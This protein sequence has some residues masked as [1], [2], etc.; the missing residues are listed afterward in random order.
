MRVYTD[1][2]GFCWWRDGDSSLG[3][4]DGRNL[5][6]SDSRFSQGKKEGRRPGDGQ[7]ESGVLGKE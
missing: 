1:G 4:V 2:V 6:R 5:C 3:Q 7:G